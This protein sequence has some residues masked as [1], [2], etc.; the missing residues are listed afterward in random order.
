M[1]HY[2]DN[3]CRQQQKVYSMRK[4]ISERKVTESL[5]NKPSWCLCDNCHLNDIWLVAKIWLTD[6]QCFSRFDILVFKALHVNFKR[7]VTKFLLSSKV[8]VCQKSK[9]RKPVEDSLS[10]HQFLFKL[11]SIY[12]LITSCCVRNKRKKNKRIEIISNIHIQTV[13]VTAVTCEIKRTATKTN[14]TWW[15]DIL[16]WVK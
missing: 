4:R 9:K 8:S 12:R 6:R 3:V 16:R 11:K 2:V 13:P 14:Q 15:H 1:C 7:V 10:C 5:E